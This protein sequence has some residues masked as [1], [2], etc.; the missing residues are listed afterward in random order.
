MRSLLF[1]ICICFFSCRPEQ[2]QH[3]AKKTEADSATHTVTDDLGR[4]VK[5]PVKLRRILS[6]APSMTEMLFALVPDSQI[7]GRTQNCNFPEAVL[8]KPVVNTYPLDLEAMLKVR[9]QAVFTVEGMTSLE[10]ANRIEELGVPVYYQ[11]Y[12]TVA[13]I[14]DRLLDLGKLLNQEAQAKALTDSLIAQLKAI[15]RSPKA[16]AK[17]RVLAVTWLDPIFVYGR[18]T[19]LTDELRLAGA[20]NAVTELFENPYPPVTREYVL[21]L[22]PD[23][24]MGRSFEHMDSSFFRLYPELK[25]TKAYL[26]KRIFEVNDDLLS[27]PSPRVVETIRILHRELHEK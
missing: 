11:K 6:L 21:K 1:S 18:N 8:Q 16:E 13:D 17:P 19:L 20:E 2:A 25:K 10:S 14:F 4:K 3:A 12:E 15:S 9:P 5:L 27:R 24:I 7:V 22:N 23:A 26:D